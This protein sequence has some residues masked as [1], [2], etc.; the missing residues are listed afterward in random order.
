MWNQGRRPIP[1]RRRQRKRPDSG[2][3]GFG[4][5]TIPHGG[6][7]KMAEAR[8]ACDRGRAR[9]RADGRGV[10]WTAARL[11]RPDAILLPSVQLILAQFP[12]D[13]GGKDT[14]RLTIFGHRYILSSDQRI[15][16]TVVRHKGGR[17]ESGPHYP[18]GQLVDLSDRSSA[19]VLG[20]AKGSRKLFHR[21]VS[22]PGSGQGG[23][24]RR[25]ER[26]RRRPHHGR[27]QVR[28]L[29]YNAPPRDLRR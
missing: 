5:A 25:C 8:F 26:R 9:G 22:R 1:R 11:Y 24:A 16:E 15:G 20:R 12:P 4:P 6:A 17:C 10:E 28:L 29:R 13:S 14:R 27:W 21:R 23:G 2:A 18:R 7:R 3:E 19:A